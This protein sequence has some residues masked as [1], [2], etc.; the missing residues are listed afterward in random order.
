M[1]CKDRYEEYK[2]EYFD[3]II[4]K[5]RRGDIKCGRYAHLVKID[6]K[7]EYNGKEL[8]KNGRSDGNKS[9]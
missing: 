1:L 8:F 7:K 2:D 4:L 5:I 6:K 3:T 9:E